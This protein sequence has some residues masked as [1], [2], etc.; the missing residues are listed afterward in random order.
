MHLYVAF[1]YELYIVRVWEQKNKLDLREIYYKSKIKIHLHNLLSPCCMQPRL[2][3]ALTAIQKRINVP[4]LYDHNNLLR[5]R[6]DIA[7]VKV[8]SKKGRRAYSNVVDEILY[9]AKLKAELRQDD[10]ERPF[11]WITTLKQ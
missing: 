4:L 11:L 10:A 9:Q 8:S 1:I 6:V 5:Q 3:D 7:K 2:T